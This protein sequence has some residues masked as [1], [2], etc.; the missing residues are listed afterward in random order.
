MKMNPAEFRV[1]FEEHAVIA[2]AQFEFRSALQ[3]LM[4]KRLQP[5]AHFIHLSLHVCANRSWQGIKRAGK[6]G[7]PDLERGGHDSLGLARSV[8]AGGD[9]AA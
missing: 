6:G 4:R 2:H 5:G 1:E 3:T 8:I 7:R 9:F